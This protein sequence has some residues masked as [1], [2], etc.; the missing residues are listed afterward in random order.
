M[1]KNCL[2]GQIA[3][4]FCAG[5]EKEE[6]GKG[7]FCSTCSLTIHQLPFFKTH[8]P[9]RIK[10]TIPPNT[11][12][13]HQKQYES[14][15][16][17]H[18]KLVCRDCLTDDCKSHQLESLTLE[19]AKVFLVSGANT[20]VDIGQINKC[21]DFKKSFLQNLE[22]DQLFLEKE[23]KSVSE[24]VDSVFKSLMEEVRLSHE[25][26]KKEIQKWYSSKKKLVHDCFE[27]QEN[28]IENLEFAKNVNTDNLQTMVNENQ[29]QN[30]L[31]LL[32]SKLLKIQKSK[33]VL[34]NP[35][36]QIYQKSLKFEQVLDV[37]KQKKNLSLI[38]F[39]FPI[40]PKKI[41]LS[42]PLN[43]SD[44]RNGVQILLDIR[45]TEN[46]PLPSLETIN[47]KVKIDSQ[48]G[49]VHTFEDFKKDPRFPQKSIFSGL[50]CAQNADHFQISAF[51]I[52]RKINNLKS[53]IF[54]QLLQ[55]SNN[56]Y[57]NQF[58]NQYQSQNQSQNQNQN[59]NQM[60]RQQQQMQQKQMQ[61]QQIQQQKIQQQQ[62]Q[63]QQIKARP[64][65]LPRNKFQP[66]TFPKKQTQPN[67]QFLNQNQNQNLKQNQNFNQNQNLG[68]NGNQNQNKNLI[69]N[70]NQMQ[71]QTQMQRQTQ[72][73]TQ[74]Q[75]QPQPQTQQ[76]QVQQLS[77]IPENLPK[78]EQ[79]IKPTPRSGLQ[80]G[81]LK[82][83][84]KFK[85]SPI[86]S[87]MLPKQK[88]KT[89][90]LG[91]NGKS[92]SSTQI[93]KDNGT[94]GEK[95][96]SN[97]NQTTNLKTSSNLVRS[98]SLNVNDSKFKEKENETWGSFLSGGFS[99]SE[100]DLAEQLDPKRS[101]KDR[102]T[103]RLLDKG[104]SLSNGSKTCERVASSLGGFKTIKGTLN[105]KMGIHKFNFK[106]D[107]FGKSIQTGGIFIGVVK[108]DFVGTAHTSKEGYT[109]NIDGYKYHKHIKE[110]YGARCLPGDIVNMVLNMDKRTITFGKNAKL[111]AVAYKKIPKDV[112][113][114]IDFTW[115]GDKLSFL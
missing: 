44:T 41:Q 68:L 9:K 70:Q 56:S 96:N 17:H 76:R 37:Q 75:T 58:P 113:V 63:Q 29:S 61:Q 73:Q 27:Q 114:V 111:W 93:F 45:D 80:V 16:P 89:P 66:N 31:V 84:F 105:Y 81:N 50:F 32:L 43:K 95:R 15:C 12:P 86:L 106:I 103:R 51:M 107:S 11:C 97:L 39:K 67:N 102:F 25:K 24:N 57:T 65:A 87:R 7:N 101:K 30:E 18:A 19:Q 42:V 79:Q 36:P 4:I 115:K 112:K 110:K 21:L 38:K 46:E 88:I 49:Q 62:I 52:N 3:T 33:D 77:L 10:V 35:Q 83:K 91:P 20:E 108:E 92:L 48:S 98:T 104:L 60:Q 6:K 2:C 82:N 47:V 59:Q 74:T 94:N 14:Y 26:A 13:K 90:T 23:H 72:T 55:S 34:S 99:D 78:T 8:K 54:F 22:K 69:Q 1:S 53:P 64:L 100:E 109:F 28:D 40:D 71:T 5:C 85:K